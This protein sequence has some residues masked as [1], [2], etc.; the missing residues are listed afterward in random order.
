MAAEDHVERVA[1]RLKLGFL[2]GALGEGGGVARDEQQSI[3]LA[4]GNV[5]PSE[6]PEQ[7]L[8]AGLR[9]TGLDEAQVASRDPGL[10]RQLELGDP[11]ALA[12]LPQESPDG[13]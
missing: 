6:D 12:P 9:A 11:P 8:A 4:K 1:H 10:E 3:L 5:E 2:E 7:H 13:L